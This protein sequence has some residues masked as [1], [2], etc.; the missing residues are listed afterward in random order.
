MRILFLLFMFYSLSSAALM[1]EGE[2]YKEKKELVELKKE[3][4]EF[5]EKKDAEFQK[6][7]KELDA[8]L[9]E[10]EK[11]KKDIETIR[12]ENKKILDDIKGAVST[13]TA[14]IYNGMKPKIA[15]GIFDKMIVDGKI[16]D[17]FG[18]ILKLKEPIV[19]KLMKYLKVENAATLTR[20]MKN[21]KEEEETK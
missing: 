12:D 20:M 13:K 10:V 14:K 1:E 11:Q 7:K 3:L 15:A 21:Y 9:A 2:L 4:N 17:V 8:I 5:Y 19:T 18:I 16:N 6:Q